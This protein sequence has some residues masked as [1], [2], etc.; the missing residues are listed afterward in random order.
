MKVRAVVRDGILGG[1]VA[2]MALAATGRI[3][4]VTLPPWNWSSTAG[5][6]LGRTLEWGWAALALSA[7]AM[8]VGLLVAFT[9]AIVFEFI[10]RRAGAWLGLLIGLFIGVCAAALAGLVPWFASWYG[11]AYTP[12]LSPFGSS[13]PAWPFVGIAGAVMLIGLVAGIGYGGPVHA[14]RGPHAIRWR[15]IYPAEKEL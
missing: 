14:G 12:W 6:T 2:A 9:C 10:T 1:V 15:Q 13:D 8:M 4:G 3:L 7:P 11:Y 5:G